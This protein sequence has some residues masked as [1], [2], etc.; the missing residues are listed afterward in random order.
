LASLV[1][2]PFWE[3]PPPRYQTIDHE[4]VPELTTA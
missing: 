1:G 2:A 3:S 4:E